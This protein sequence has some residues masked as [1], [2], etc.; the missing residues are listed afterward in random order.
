MNTSFSV[1]VME[2]H[3]VLFFAYTET[4]YSTAVRSRI[5]HC[6][7]VLQFMDIY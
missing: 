2:D 6:V 3:C 1:A 5:V 4:W 7:L